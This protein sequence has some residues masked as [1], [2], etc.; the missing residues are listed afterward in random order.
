MALNK[1]VSDKYLEKYTAV[2]NAVKHLNQKKKEHIM[3]IVS[4]KKV[5]IDCGTQIR[6][7]IDQPTV[8]TYCEAM[9]GGAEFP[10]VRIFHDG[11]HYYL[12]DGFHRYFAAQKAKRTGIEAEV[13]AGT[14]SEAILYAL[15]ANDKHGKPRTIEDK[16]NAV[17]IMVNHFE[18][19]GYSNKEIAKICNVSEQFVSKLRV[20]KEPDVIKYKMADGEVR[21]RKRT[22]KKEKP[23]KKETKDTSPVVN[24]S[25]LETANEALE[26]LIEENQKLVDQLAVNLSEDPSHTQTHIK[27]LRQQIKDM[28]MELRA[29]KLSRDQYQNEN[30]EL[31]KQ[32]KWL[33][34]KIKKLETEIL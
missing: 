17:M 32:I 24:E 1:E 16:T 9:L 10:P 8:D 14:L 18:W 20:G 5:R 30:D 34:K 4:I 27:E 29:V 19:S 6:K 12:A 25:K 31:K 2:Q 26:I 11:V 7:E 33:E 21:E 23:K 3:Q 15:G 28:E 13:T 22:T